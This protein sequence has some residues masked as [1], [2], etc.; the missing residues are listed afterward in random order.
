LSPRID[1]TPMVD[2]GFLLITFFIF[3]TT[4]TQHKVMTINMPYKDNVDIPSEPPAVPNSVALTLMLSKE[5]KVFYYE[6]SPNSGKPDIKSTGFSEADGVRQV[7][8][9]KRN[10]VEA[11]KRAGE[12][13]ELF[14]TTVFIKPDTGSCY[15]D[16]VH[17]LDEM[18]VNDIKVYTIADISEQE[19]QWMK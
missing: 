19:Q 4:L 5:H 9:K 8:E 3:T 17:V 15:A 13:R 2:L 7:I 12:L 1:L 6:G 14:Q 18:L 11:R 16:L 10:E